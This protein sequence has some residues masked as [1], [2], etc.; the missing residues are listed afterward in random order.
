MFYY[1]TKLAMTNL[2]T[3]SWINSM[4]KKSMEQGKVPYINETQFHLIY[5]P[6]KTE[7]R[8]A[9]ES[10]FLERKEAEKE[11]LKLKIEKNELIDKYNDFDRELKSVMAQPAKTP[12]EQAEKMKRI[13]SIKQKQE[14]LLKKI[15]EKNEKIK[16]QE[17]YIESLNEKIYELAEKIREQEHKQSEQDREELNY[18]NQEKIKDLKSQ[19]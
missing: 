13:G 8:N 6:K 19:L 11:R 9:I 17:E 3:L 16:N 7:T 5:S 1:V 2:N 12:E 18:L 10:K 4:E 15:K 14:D